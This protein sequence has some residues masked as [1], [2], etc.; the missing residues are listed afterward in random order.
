MKNLTPNWTLSKSHQKWLT[1][2][3]TSLGQLNRSGQTH[4][5][6]E[7]D[8]KKFLVWF[9]VVRRKK[10]TKIKSSDIENYTQFLEK[11][12]LLRR[13][14][15]L[16][17]RLL[18]FFKIRKKQN[19]DLIWPQNPLKVNSRRR[20]LSS[21][22]NFFEYLKQ[23]H[24]EKWWSRFKKNPIKSKLHSITLKQSDIEHTKM[25][26]PEHFERLNEA[27][28]KREMRLALHL[29]Y[30]GGLRLHELTLL[31]IDCFDIE[32][33]SMTFARK[34]GKV[35]QLRL[36]NFREIERLL[37][38]HLA[39]R[40]INSLYLFP[41]KSGHK[42]LGTRAWALRLERLFLKAGLPSGLTPHSLRKACATELYFKYR[43]LLFVRD[44]LN[45]TDAKVTQTY[46]D[47]QTLWQRDSSLS[48]SNP[49]SYDRDRPKELPWS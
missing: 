34:G 49:L 20:H 5:S 17:M 41:S 6:Y 3:L 2:Y 37:A 19:D 29:L 15:N 39:T 43:D 13:P 35:H 7:S 16:W 47:S 9:E 14:Q 30:Y 26:T 12:G 36:Q 33:Q 22:K 42:A 23:H 24:E 21:L 38:I 32:S 4:Q 46:I 10:I 45:H 48:D 8:L 11:G 31:H 44:Y 28:T 1:E 25:L 40:K 18:I 27:C